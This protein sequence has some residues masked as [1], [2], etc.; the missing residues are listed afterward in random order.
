MIREKIKFFLILFIPV[1]ILLFPQISFALVFQIDSINTVCNGSVAEARIYW[2][3]EEGIPNPTF[4][5]QRQKQGDL[6]FTEIGT[7]QEKFYYDSR[8]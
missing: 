1:F 7:T 6:G 3:Y 5:I 2:T 4:R 8:L